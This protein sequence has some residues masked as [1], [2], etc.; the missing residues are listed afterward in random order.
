VSS[1]GSV[2]KI[3]NAGKGGGTRVIMPEDFACCMCGTVFL[4]SSGDD[5]FCPNCGSSQIRK[6]LGYNELSD[7]EFY[8]T[9]LEEERKTNILF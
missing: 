2:A 4:S 3:G 5:L 7:E 1:T 6:E 8:M 9:I